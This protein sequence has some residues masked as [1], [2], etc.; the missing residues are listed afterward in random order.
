MDEQIKIPKRILASLLNSISAGVVPRSGAHYIA[1]G[2]DDEISALLSD[3]E[4]INE[5]GASMRFIIGKYGSGK[6]FLMQLVRGYSLERGFITADA[7]LSPER[8]ICG[9]KGTGVATY[10]ELMKNLSSKTSPD[11]GALA[12]II[13]KWL[14]DLQGEIASS[15]IPTGDLRF[16]AELQARIFAVVRDIESQIGGFDFAS[17]IGA[18]YNAYVAGDESTKSACLRWLRG[19]YNTKTEAK[20]QLRVQSIIDDDNWYDYIK[21][22]AVFFRKI[23]YRGFV[24]FI[25][26]CVNL[27]KITN[28]ISRENNYEKLLS[29]FNDTLQGKAV[30]LGLILGG[31]PQ[32]LEDTRRGL[33]SYEALRSRLCDGRFAASGFKN[34]IG[35]VIR[36]RRLSDDELFALITRLTKFHAQ[37]Y[38]WEPRITT[39]EMAAFMLHCTSRAGADT[40]ITPREIIRDYMTVL[41]ILMQNPDADCAAIMGSGVVTLKSMAIADDDA[42][43]SEPSSDGD[44]M[45]TTESPKNDYTLEDIEF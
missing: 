31:T 36:L 13:T 44:T 27:Y 14:S 28:R 12:G 15:G 30:G 8:R 42:P 43:I 24:V 10:R 1:I 45:P 34:L 22:L 6:S 9:A 26:E 19:E 25:D 7:D 16:A 11:G 3:L 37:Y 20:A 38:N 4:S 21:L 18:Y 29:M 40:M 5:G 33:F 17:V 23:G 35:P 32:F 39:E 41:N 2:R